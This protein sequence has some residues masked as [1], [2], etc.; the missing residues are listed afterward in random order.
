MQCVCEHQWCQLVLIFSYVRRL[1]LPVSEPFCC[2]VN[3]LRSV[4]HSR[5]CVV[6]QETLLPD[7]PAGGVSEFGDWSVQ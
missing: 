6:M 5:R 2:A 4:S 1:R 7:F 3:V